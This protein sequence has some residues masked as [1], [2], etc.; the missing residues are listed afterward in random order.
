MK[1]YLVHGVAST[2]V[3]RCLAAVAA[4]TLTTGVELQAQG[5]ATRRDTVMLGG[6]PI[7]IGKQVRLHLA[8]DGHL[9]GRLAQVTDGA[10]G[11]L[12]LTGRSHPIDFA[13][14]DSLWVKESEAATVAAIS[15]L[16]A[17]VAS[18]WLL[19][20]V[21]AGLGDGGGCSE[22]G[23]VLLVSLPI[24]GLGALIG[25]AMGA[26]NWRWRLAYVRTR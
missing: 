3:R 26:S 24:A 12:L 23:T 13:S 9:E 11:S 4:L 18:V 1:R 6:T 15:G 22:S 10:E 17:G 19:T 5:A 7:R 14:V 2:L 8:G 20:E 16:V 21:C 25:H